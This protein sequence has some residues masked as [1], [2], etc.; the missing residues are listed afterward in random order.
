MRAQVFYH[1]LRR[2]PGRAMNY[3]GDD[4]R[5][6]CHDHLDT[7]VISHDSLKRP[8]NRI[9]VYICDISFRGERHLDRE[10]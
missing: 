5:R 2:R 8:A 9:C 1:L 6:C 4:H 7:H 10:S 3:D